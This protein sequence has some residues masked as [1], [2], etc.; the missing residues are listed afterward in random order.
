V[1]NEIIMVELK[2]LVLFFE[3]VNRTLDKGVGADGILGA[4]TSLPFDEP[5]EILKRVL[6]SSP[7]VDL[8]LDNQQLAL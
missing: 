1:P 8:G 3:Q 6:S 7:P 2:E 5:D 4:A